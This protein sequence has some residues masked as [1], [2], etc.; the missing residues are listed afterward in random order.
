MLGHR[1]RSLVARSSCTPGACACARLLPVPS[2]R[3]HP[4]RLSGGRSPEHWQLHCAAA[5]LCLLP[6]ADCY[7][8]AAG[9]PGWASSSSARGSSTAAAAGPQP[10]CCEPRRNVASNPAQPRPLTRLWA[11]SMKKQVAT[12]S[13]LPA[14]E[15]SEYTSCRF[16]CG[17][18][19]GRGWE[20]EAS[21]APG[22][23]QGRRRE[24]CRGC[25]S[26]ML[27][28]AAPPAAQR[29]LAASPCGAAVRP[30]ASPGTR[31][32][33]A[34]RPLQTSPRAARGSAAQRPG[35][36]AAGPS[37]PAPARHQPGTSPPPARQRPGRAPAT[38]P[39][40]SRRPPWTAA[41]GAASCRRAP[42]RAPSGRAAGPRPAG[43]CCCCE[44]RG[45]PPAAPPP[46]R[47]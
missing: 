4:R 19:G 35:A 12:Q 23:A 37:S 44:A 43:G 16:V 28:L 11:V 1:C 6:D 20:G 15:G 38:N 39:P 2:R 22:G 45:A 25:T 5:P 33:S 7:C 46:L 10:T 21:L 47:G 18:G 29:G 8:H 17:G 34:L 32:A 14:M 42:G 24:C 36:A 26:W 30:P 40:Q 31:R 3:A 27:W 41:P 13:K 9:P